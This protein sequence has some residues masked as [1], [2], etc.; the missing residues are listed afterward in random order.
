MSKTHSFL[1]TCL[2]AALTAGILASPI[3]EAC[4]RFV[5]HGAH[6]EVITAR[7]MDWKTDV[8]TNLWAF[9]RGMARSG[10]A[11]PN[12]VHWVSKY[13]SVIASAG[14]SADGWQKGLP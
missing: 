3:A 8:A 14:P 4:T 7:S 2:T 13:G 1:A 6:D 5:Y 11:G 10:E 12:S 9:P